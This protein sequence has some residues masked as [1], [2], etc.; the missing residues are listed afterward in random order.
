MDTSR[1]VTSPLRIDAVEVPGTG[2]GLIGMTECP[3]RIV[4]TGSGIPVGPWKRDLDLDLRVILDWQAQILVSLIEDYEF[5]LYGV[6]ELP[7]KTANLGIRWLQLPVA[8]GCIPDSRLEEAWDAAGDELRRALANGGRILLH[9]RTGLGRSGTIAARL[10]VEF[11]MTPCEAFTAVRR[12]RPGAIQSG[13]Q[14]DYV[15]GCRRG[16]H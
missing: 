9:G 5:E 10:L 8:D 15:R 11:G 16:L 2:G 14:E 4:I 3:G 1:S 12:A 7:V 13:E 6:S